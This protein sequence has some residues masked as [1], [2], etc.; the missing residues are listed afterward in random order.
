M[1]YNGSSVLARAGG[2]LGTR[3]RDSLFT[4]PTNVP[5]APWL[6]G[7]APS[8]PTIGPL[9]SASVTVAPTGGEPV[10]WWVVSWR[11]NGAWTPARRVWGASRS[12]VRPPAM[13]A[14]DAVAV[15][16]LSRAGNLSEP[17]VSTR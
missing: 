9:A 3:V 4:T 17:A 1:F 10:R 11:V 8:R 15:W 14:A 6:G 16:A 2:A 12:I 13:S 5:A 7:R